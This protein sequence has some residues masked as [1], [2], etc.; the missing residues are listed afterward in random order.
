M[1]S[2][3]TPPITQM[4]PI[5][6]PTTPPMIMTMTPAT[7]RPRPMMFTGMARCSPVGRTVLALFGTHPL[8]RLERTVEVLALERG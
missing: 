5:I 1:N 4:T 6:Q 3:P 2:A 8:E 7:S